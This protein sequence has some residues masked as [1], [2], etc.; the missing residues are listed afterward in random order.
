MKGSPSQALDSFPLAIATERH[1]PD[2]PTV[3]AHQPGKSPAKKAT[4]EVAL[5]L[6]AGVLGDP[7]RERLVVDRAVQRL[8][9]VP[10]QLVER[11]GLWRSGSLNA[12]AILH[13]GIR[14][15]GRGTGGYA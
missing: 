13:T 10:H 6:L 15:G 12:G 7:H 9:V 11:R 14:A 1:E 4:L 3:P 5:Q 8:E 2:L